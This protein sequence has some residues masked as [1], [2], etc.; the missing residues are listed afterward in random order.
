MTP[1]RLSELKRLCAAATPGPWTADSFAMED[2]ACVR[3]A[4]TDGSPTYYHNCAWICE[5]AVN[6]TADD[7]VDDLRPGEPKIG[8]VQAERNAA[9]I[10]ALSPQAVLELIA[11]VETARERALEEA[12]A[13]VPT[14]WLSSLL[15]G[16]VASPSGPSG[17]RKVGF[18]ERDIETLLLGIQDKI[19]SLKLKPGAEG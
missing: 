5:C 19:R 17:A 16:P 12:S 18:S 2:D 11:E 8:V 10:A 13:C 1:E 7:E 9:F 14:S 15:T 3:V 6:Y 4:T